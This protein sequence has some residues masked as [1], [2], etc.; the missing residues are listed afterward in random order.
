MPAADDQWL[1]LNLYAAVALRAFRVRSACPACES[2]LLSFEVWVGDDYD[3]R[4]ADA[5]ERCFA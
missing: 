5:T 3:Q 2:G 1:Q 4:Y